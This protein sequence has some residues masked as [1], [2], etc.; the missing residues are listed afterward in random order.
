MLYIDF[1][2]RE[3]VDVAKNLASLPDRLK[4]QRPGAHEFTLA[5]VSLKNVGDE[6]KMAA[7][8]ELARLTAEAKIGMN[9][10]Y[11]SPTGDAVTFAYID[12]LKAVR[13]YL[14]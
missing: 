14:I 13:F 5:F 10:E 7:A 12:K 11:K 6:E 3:T 8:R 4:Q 1:G 2:N 9:V